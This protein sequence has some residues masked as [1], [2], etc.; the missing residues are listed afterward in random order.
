MCV[1]PWLNLTDYGAVQGLRVVQQVLCRRLYSSSRLGR[2][3]L[4]LARVAAMTS[5]CVVWL[6][7]FSRDTRGLGRGGAK[8][9]GTNKTSRCQSCRV[10]KHRV[11]PSVQLYFGSATFRKDWAPPESCDTG[12]SHNK[13]VTW[14]DCTWRGGWESLSAQRKVSGVQT[15]RQDS[16]ER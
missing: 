10:L 9:L 5:I 3:L 14:C 8:T 15:N 6:S 13:P 7:T 16:M 2:F 4:A 12:K 11:L 1:Q